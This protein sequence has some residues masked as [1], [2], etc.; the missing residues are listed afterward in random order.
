M[1][2]IFSISVLVLILILQNCSET[3][4]PQIPPLQINFPLNQKAVFAEALYADLNG[5]LSL[6][7]LRISSLLFEE[8]I[9]SNDTTYLLGQTEQYVSQTFQN[10]GRY[11]GGVK[12]A[13]TAQWVV[14]EYVPENL[15]SDMFFKTAVDCTEK[16]L[17]GNEHFP[18]APR[19][20]EKNKTFEL[21]REE[22]SGN[23]WKLKKIHRQFKI[24]NDFKWE[25]QYGFE[26]GL[27]VETAEFPFNNDTLFYTSIYD[28]HGVFISQTSYN[29]LIS[30]GAQTDTLLLHKLNRRIKDFENPLFIENLQIYAEQIEQTDLKLIYR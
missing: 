4:N 8:S 29:I 19:I 11:N 30:D 20:L 5:S 2:R 9:T 16:A 28:E 24:G 15:S 23:N 12:I 6:Q 21:I 3:N 14:M 27:Y 1:T 17:P 13:L 18:I 25:D 10:S 7:N 26:D 22:S